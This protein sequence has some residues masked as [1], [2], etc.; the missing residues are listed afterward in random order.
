[1]N[2]KKRALAV[3]LGTDTQCLLQCARQRFAEQNSESDL[4]CLWLRPTPV[5]ASGGDNNHDSASISEVQDYILA[6]DEACLSRLYYKNETRTWCGPN[7]GLWQDEITSN[8]LFGKLAAYE[9]LPRLYHRLMEIANTLTDAADTRLNYY[10]FAPLHDPFASGALF[11]VAY[12]LH[13]LALDR[14]GGVYGMLLLPGISADPVTCRDN[15]SSDPLLRRAVCY[16]ALRELHFFS[17]GQSFFNHYHPFPV[18]QDQSP[19]QSGDCYLIGGDQIALN[20]K[21]VGEQCAW[22]MYLQTCTRMADALPRSD[23]NRSVFSAFGAAIGDLKTSS[24]ASDSLNSAALQLA[25]GLLADDAAG[26]PASDVMRPHLSP[27]FEEAARQEV[28]S[29]TADRL[30]ADLLATIDAMHRKNLESLRRYEEQLAGSAGSQHK[31]VSQAVCSDMARLVAQPGMNLPNLHRTLLFNQRQVSDS[32]AASEARRKEIEQQATTAAESLRDSRARYRYVQTFGGGWLTCLALVGLVIWGLLLLIGLSLGQL[33]LMALSLPALLSAGLAWLYRR[34]QIALAQTELIGDYRQLMTLLYQLVAAR[35]T[36]AYLHT[37]NTHLMSTLLKQAKEIE[38]K[39]NQLHQQMLD[40]ETPLPSPPYNLTAVQQHALNYCWQRG[41]SLSVGDLRHFIEQTTLEQQVL[42][43]RFGEAQMLYQ[44]VAEVKATCAPMLNFKPGVI[45][46]HDRD[47][48]T[49]LA[50]IPADQMADAAAL[51]FDTPVQWIELDLEQRV[52][53][54]LRSN[55]PLHSL[56]GITQWQAAYLQCCAHPHPSGDGVVMQRALLHPTRLGIAAP[57]PCVP[58]D[59][60]MPPLASILVVLLRL[61]QD[62]HSPAGATKIDRLCQRLNVARTAY[63]ELCGA[64]QDDPAVIRWLLRQGQP[65]EQPI[66]IL[67][68]AFARRASQPRVSERYADWELW[69]EQRLRQAV[70]EDLAPETL[71]GAAR[72]F[73]WLEL[74]ITDGV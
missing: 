68:E 60:Q 18:Y 37:L 34:Q 9:H 19:F 23:R 64:L 5:G 62:T 66:E 24:A 72:F 58:W 15:D 31:R 13:R 3:G 6:L 63:D 52:T 49:W 55:I 61:Y 11:D 7:W 33:S 8:R 59:G 26:V 41:N 27:N 45:A 25:R 30:D 71:A 14:G 28:Y 12:L 42:N 48:V 32:Y 65:V 53:L 54:T 21:T 70:E 73:R 10:L 40:Q 22:W 47:A 43:Q 67:R 16:A 44:S 1:M 57:D 50:G 51:T 2:G 39:V 38:E 35:A 4:G 17:G 56:T 20:F 46:Q 74:E 29:G 36:S 69:T